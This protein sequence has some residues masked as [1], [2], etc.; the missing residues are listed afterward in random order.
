MSRESH[1]DTLLKVQRTL[2]AWVHGVTRPAGETRLFQQACDRAAQP[3]LAPAQ[4]AAPRHGYISI[5]SVPALTN[6]KLCGALSLY[7]GERETYGPTIAGPDGRKR[8]EAALRLRQAG[9]QLRVDCIPVPVPVTAPAGA[10]AHRAGDAYNV[11]NRHRRGIREWVTRQRRGK[12]E[13][14][15]L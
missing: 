15:S 6:E 8:A 5:L 13:G 12:K 10:A 11:E 4:T 7:F 9:F 14:E 2:T 1:H 3:S